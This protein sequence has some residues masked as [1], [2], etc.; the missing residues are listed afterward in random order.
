MHTLRSTTIALASRRKSL[1]L[2]P[3]LMWALDKLAD[4]RQCY[5]G[6]G[7]EEIEERRKVLEIA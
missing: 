2:A 3:A 6:V 4:A 1:A 7:A 5:G